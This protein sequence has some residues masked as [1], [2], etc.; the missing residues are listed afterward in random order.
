MSYEY[1]VMVH[2]LVLWLEILGAAI[3]KYLEDAELERATLTDDGS[4]EKEVVT[5][6]YA[7]IKFKIKF[8]RYF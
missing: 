7:S 1:I 3:P 8:L 4:W 5:K 2:R 6:N